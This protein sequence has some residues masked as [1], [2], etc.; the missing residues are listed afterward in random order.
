MSLVY[1][2]LI[3]MT[4]YH[5]IQ[6]NFSFLRTYLLKTISTH[7]KIL[8]RMITNVVIFQQQT[9]KCF[10]FRILSIFNTHIEG[11]GRR[12]FKEIYSGVIQKGLTLGYIVQALNLFYSLI[13]Q[14]GIN[15][16]FFLLRILSI[17][18]THTH[19]RGEGRIFF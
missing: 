13:F 7:K 2:I 14:C 19:I 12:F 5:L 3:Q 18:N 4:W 6:N 15:P 17:F 10:F 11:E 9:T 16:L 8:L 1:W